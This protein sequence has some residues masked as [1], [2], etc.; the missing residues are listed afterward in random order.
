MGQSAGG[1]SVRT[2]VSSPL[3]K[4]KICG[5]VI[6][7]GGGYKSPFPVNV[8]DVGRLEEACALYLEQKGMGLEDMY[9]KTPQE[10][11]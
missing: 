8:I 3:V 11:L 4:W 10:I 5:A 2:L 7:S 6:Q 9:E 1:M